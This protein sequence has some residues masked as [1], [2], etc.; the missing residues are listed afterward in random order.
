MPRG[1]QTA[2]VTGGSGFIGGRLVRRLAGEG[3]QVRA[4]ARSDGSV[5]AVSELGAEAVRGELGDPAAMAL[6]AEGCE[7]SF[8]LAAHVAD[9]GPMEDFVRGNIDGTRNALEASRRARV[10]RFVSMKKGSVSSSGR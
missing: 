7:I 10:R 4:L 6:G 2:F 3:V 5:A 1:F 9:W 8:H